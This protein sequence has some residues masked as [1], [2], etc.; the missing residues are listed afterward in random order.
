MPSPAEHFC[1]H[2]GGYVDPTGSADGQGTDGTVWWCSEVCRQVAVDGLWPSAVGPA[3]HAD[4]VG[5]IEAEARNPNP[6]GSDVEALK[7]KLLALLDG[8][9]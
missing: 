3:S 4:M 8:D 5:W 6:T 7:A 1:A 2:C 9:A